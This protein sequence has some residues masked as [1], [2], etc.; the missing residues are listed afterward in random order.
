MEDTGKGRP[1]AASDGTGDVGAHAAADGT[2]SAGNAGT[3]AAVVGTVN[4][5]NAGAHAAA[6]GTGSAGKAGTH[7]YV[8][9]PRNADILIGIRDGVSQ[10]FELVWRPAAKVSV[11]DSGFMLGDGVW[12]GIRLHRGVLLFDR[13]RSCKVSVLDS[14][15]ML[16]DGFWEGIRLHRGVLL[17]DRVRPY[18]KRV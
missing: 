18:N 4:T 12:E 16:G 15:F 1:Q 13:V 5:G 3:Q 2:G 17:F 7:V 14:G 10:R 11:L 9:D 8:D 6:D